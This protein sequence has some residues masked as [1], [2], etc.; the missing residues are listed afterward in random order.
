MGKEG[1]NTRDFLIGTFVGGIIGA[2]TALFLAPKSGK[3][4]R[5]DIGS[6]AA[7]IKDK[8]CKLTNEAREKG[9]EY[10]S[11]AKDKTSSISQLVSD[12]S[13]Q[14]MDKVKDLRAPGV[15]KAVELKENAASAIDEAEE[16]T[17]TEGKETET[18]QN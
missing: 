13:T 1:M 12:R 10:V 11:I 18:A 5:D 15:E 3:E 7:V 14:L 4:L 17:K 16:E 8:T 9:A 2:A 6:Q